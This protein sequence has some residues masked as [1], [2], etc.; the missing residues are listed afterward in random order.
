MSNSASV[1]ISIFIV[2]FILFCYS[3]AECLRYNYSSRLHPLVNSILCSTQNKF[4]QQLNSSTMTAK[5]RS[6]REVEERDRLLLAI[7][8][9]CPLPPFTQRTQDPRAKKSPAISGGTGDYSRSKRSFVC[10]SEAINWSW[11]SLYFF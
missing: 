6:R 8:P 4:I 11:R 7:T 10:F 9:R 1:L 3:S 5:K 2:Y